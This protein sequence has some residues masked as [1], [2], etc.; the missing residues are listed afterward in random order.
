MEQEEGIKLGKT[1]GMRRVVSRFKDPGLPETIYTALGDSKLYI[2]GK[3]LSAIHDMESPCY[4]L[5]SASI[6]ELVRSIP[7]KAEFHKCFEGAYQMFEAEDIR[8]EQESRL[9]PNYPWKLAEEV[10]GSKIIWER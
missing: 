9:W 4:F 2:S 1:K 8:W 10:G 6:H 5:P 3:A 7:T